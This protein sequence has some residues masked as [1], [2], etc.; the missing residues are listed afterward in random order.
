MASSSTPSAPTKCDLLCIG[1][2]P[3]GMAVSIM[4]SA[5]G[6]NV[7]AIEKDK[8]G[9][10][11]QNVGCIPSKALLRVSKKHHTAAKHVGNANLPIPEGIFERIQESLDYIGEKKTKSMFDKVDLKSGTAK[12][13]GNKIVEVNGE[14]YTGKYVFVCVG[15]HPAVP[16]I[17]GLD[18]LDQSRIITN[19]TLWKLKKVPDSLV[20]LGGGAIGCEIGQ[21]MS[22]LGS[23]V[24]MIHMDKHLVPLGDEEAAEI[25]E[26]ELVKEGITVMNDRKISKAYDENGMIV[27]ESDKQEKA[28]GEILLVAAGRS[29]KHMQ[30]LDLDKTGVNVD[31]RGAIIVNKYLQSSNSDIFGCGDCN[32]HALLSHAAMHQGMLALMNAIMPKMSRKNFK[33]YVVP[34]T[35]FTEPQFSQ[36]GQTE[37][38]LQ[39]SGIKYDVI[40]VKYEDYGAAVAENID[41]GF[42]KVFTDASGKIYGAVIIGEGSAEMINEMGLAI[43]GKMKMEDIMMLQHSF[44]SMSF[45]IKRASEKWMMNYFDTQPAMWTWY[46]KLFV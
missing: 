21:A 22:R 32:G 38:Q 34:W 44:P 15:T 9:G 33:D 3:A 41:I 23:K 36:V 28:T 12:F 24:T 37:K 26:K 35:V 7:I 6:M 45:L 39:E 30:S 19:E 18:T 16:P 43:Q 14:T 17:P 10:E 8:I 40:K 25:L 27:L 5:M 46:K 4:G 29:W 42:V 2:G 11:C 1:L 13:V 20:I 31:K